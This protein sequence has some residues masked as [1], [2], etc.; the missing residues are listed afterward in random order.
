MSVQ[1]QSTLAH[2]DKPPSGSTVIFDPTC[3]TTNST[4]SDPQNQTVSSTQFDRPVR[5]ASTYPATNDRQRR[6]TS[7]FFNKRRSEFYDDD[8]EFYDG[9]CG[10]IR[11]FGSEI[12][13]RFLELV[14]RTEKRDVT[15]VN[16]KM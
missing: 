7:S 3:V 5:P 6:M 1:H 2:H 4:I 16:E 9:C 13:Y 14:R 10:S 8:D 15:D 12:K 11:S